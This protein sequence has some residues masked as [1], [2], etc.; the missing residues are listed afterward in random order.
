VIDDD[1]PD[2]DP[3]VLAARIQAAGRRLPAP[4]SVSVGDDEDPDPHGDAAVDN[5]T[6]TEWD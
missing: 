6:F 3:R 5:I 1:A 2:P 4:T